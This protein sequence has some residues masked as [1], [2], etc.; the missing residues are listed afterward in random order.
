LA[1][2]EIRKA[3]T[4]KVISNFLDLILIAYFYDKEFSGPD[5]LAFIRNQY[6]I[7]L[8]SG[9]AYS[10]LYSMERE[11][12]I[13]GFDTVGKRRYKVSEKGKQTLEVARNF[14]LTKTLLSQNSGRTS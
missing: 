14:E 7:T 11:N 6:G 13:D 4:K 3:L 9:T 12:L 10:A 1:E 8:S 2:E 5:V